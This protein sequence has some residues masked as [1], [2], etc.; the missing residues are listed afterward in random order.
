[1]DL[2]LE[3]QKTTVEIKISILKIPYVPIF[4]AKQTTLT[5]WAQICI[6][7]DFGVGISKI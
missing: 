7:M 6:K 1:M 5:F 4:Q 2:E 3:I